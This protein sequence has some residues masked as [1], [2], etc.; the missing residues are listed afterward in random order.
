MHDMR[1]AAPG[2]TA[3]RIACGG[4]CTSRS[5]RRR[6]CSKAKLAS[7]WWLQTKAGAAA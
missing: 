1:T 2:S 7:D 6:T 4:P 3:V 5:M